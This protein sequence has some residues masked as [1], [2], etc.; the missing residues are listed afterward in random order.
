MSVN[1]EEP[2]EQKSNIT[3]ENIQDNIWAVRSI[4]T[5]TLNIAAY[6]FLQL[7]H[8]LKSHQLRPCFMYKEEYSDCKSIQ[9]RFHQYFIHG[10]SVDC[11][12]WKRDFDNCERFEADPSDLNAVKEVLDS[13]ANRRTNRLRAHYQNNTWTKRD[14]PPADWAKPLPEWLVE[15]NKNTYLAVKATE[16]N[17]VEMSSGRPGFKEE[18]T[19]CVIM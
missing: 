5:F 1:A 7:K 13:E 11:L 14:A 17:E 8:V 4:F 18:R 10:D 3:H 9:A 2:K 16:M 15:K 19:L 6:Y 12:Q